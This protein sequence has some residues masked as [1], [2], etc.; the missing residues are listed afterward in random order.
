VAKLT[1]IADMKNPEGFTASSGPKMSAASIKPTVCIKFLVA[2]DK[3]FAW[4]RDSGGTTLGTAA[5]WAGKKKALTLESKKGV[6]NSDQMGGECPFAKSTAKAVRMTALKTSVATMILRRSTL[7]ARTPPNGLR[8]KKG[9]AVTA[10]TKPTISGR[11]VILSVMN[12]N[13]RPYTASPNC[14]TV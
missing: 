1:A 7:S 6:T 4:M 13:K 5:P 9:T 11:C 14:D 2:D 8:N 10:A 12:K 3:E